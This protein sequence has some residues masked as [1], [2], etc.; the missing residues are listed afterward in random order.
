MGENKVIAVHDK[1]LDKISKIE[2]SHPIIT[3]KELEELKESYV[4]T[5]ELAKKSRF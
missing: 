3:D 1:K 5:A 2:R 4:K